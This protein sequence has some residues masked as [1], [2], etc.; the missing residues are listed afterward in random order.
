MSQPAP[1]GCRV[2]VVQCIPSCHIV[3]LQ[4]GSFVGRSILTPCRVNLTAYT[5]LQADLLIGIELN[6]FKILAL[7]S[8]RELSIQLNHF[9]FL[10]GCCWFFLEQKKYFSAVEPSKLLWL[11]FCLG[12]LSSLLEPMPYIIPVRGGSMGRTGHKMTVDT[13]KLAWVLCVLSHSEESAHYT[14]GVTYE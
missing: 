13:C 9:I 3:D 6:R 1:S 2:C 8:L 11:D 7:L 5:S 14:C 10:F 12:L 4:K